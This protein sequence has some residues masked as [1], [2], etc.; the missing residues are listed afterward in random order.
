MLAKAVPGHIRGG[1]RE[2]EAP[3]CTKT[4]PAMGLLPVDVVVAGIWFLDRISQSLRRLENRARSV[5]F[6][7]LVPDCVPALALHALFLKNR[8]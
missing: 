3:G 4:T 6:A 2:T 8:P 5:V 7:I 1:L